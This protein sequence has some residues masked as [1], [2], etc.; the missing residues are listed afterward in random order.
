MKRFILCLVILIF[1][2]PS[3][4][5]DVTIAV[6]DLAERGVNKWAAYAAS[7]IVRAEFVNVGNFTVVDTTDAGLRLRQPDLSDKQ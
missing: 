1:A 7:D 6:L 5:D 3:F 4:A 2:A